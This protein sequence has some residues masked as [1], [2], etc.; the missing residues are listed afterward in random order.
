MENRGE[1]CGKVVGKLGKNVESYVTIG[2]LKRSL[3][4]KAA[5]EAKDSPKRLTVFS[6]P[7]CKRMK[8]HR[9]AYLSSEMI[10]NR[11]C[12]A[13]WRD[14]CDGAKGALDGVELSRARSLDQRS[15]AGCVGA[16]YVGASSLCRRECCQRILPEG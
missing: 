7:L 5:S 2:C 4:L 14:S 8:L 6:L 12:F 1:N 16:V 13:R 15:A 3:A 10:E 9:A 11:I